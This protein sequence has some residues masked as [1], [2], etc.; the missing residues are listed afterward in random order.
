MSKTMIL[1]LAA[2]LSLAACETDSGPK[3]TG[4]ALIGAIVGGLLGSKIGGGSGQLA[5]TAAGTLLGGYLGSET[6]RSLDRADRV[7]AE[8][9]AQQSLESKPSGSA[10]TWVN[11]DTGHSGTITPTNTYRSADGLHCRDYQQTVTI[12]GRSETVHGT[13]CREKD[14]AWRVVNHR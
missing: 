8:R 13:A 5:A 6:G 4:G 11:P 12:E 10:S 2:I 14:G 7:Y 3:Q 9:A 1:A